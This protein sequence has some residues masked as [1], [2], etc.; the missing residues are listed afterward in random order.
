MPKRFVVDGVVTKST[1]Q[2]EVDRVNTVKAKRTAVGALAG[3]TVES[4]DAGELSALVALLAEKAGALDAAGN[5]TDP[6]NWA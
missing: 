5:L 6:A 2:A 3:R 1:A 4:L